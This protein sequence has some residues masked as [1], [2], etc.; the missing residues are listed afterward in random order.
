FIGADTKGTYEVIIGTDSQAQ[1]GEADFVSALIVHK[2]GR[3][4]I[5]FWSRQKVENLHNLKQRIWQEALISLS[6]AE[7]LVGDFAAIGL[8]D[9]DLEIHVDVGP[10]GPTREMIADVVGMIRAN[11]FRV[12]TKPASWGASHVADRHV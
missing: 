8:F 6:V 4:G 1:S 9:L 7:K 10:N 5:Y 11:G 3:G 2:K 12:A